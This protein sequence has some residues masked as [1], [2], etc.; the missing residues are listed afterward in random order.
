MKRYNQKA[1]E[2]VFLENSEEV[3]VNGD[4]T[5]EEKAQAR[6][7]ED[8]LASK[9]VGKIYRIDQRHY[10]GEEAG[11]ITRDNFLMSAERESRYYEQ[12]G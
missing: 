12:N 10:R 11:E 3:I 8:L 4:S 2:N 9:P 7:I 5:P 6:A 1:V